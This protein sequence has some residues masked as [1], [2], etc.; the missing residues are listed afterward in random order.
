MNGI[1]READKAGWLLND[2]LIEIV[3]RGWIGFNSDWVENG[4]TDRKINNTKSA[5]YDGLGEAF[6]E[7]ARSGIN[8]PAEN[9]GQRERG[10]K[11]FMLADAKA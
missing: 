9:D 3:A 2:A 8:Q 5:S 6:R 11:I 10:A 1:L 7:I 4:N